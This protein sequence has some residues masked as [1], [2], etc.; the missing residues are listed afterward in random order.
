MAEPDH[1]TAR[2]MAGLIAERVAHINLSQRQ[3]SELVGSST[4]HVCL[5]FNG[6]ATAH[7][8]T[9]DR[10]AELLGV[11]FDVAIGSSPNFIDQ[12]IA[13]LKEAGVHDE[14]E[15]DGPSDLLDEVRTA[16]ANQATLR[17]AVDFLEA[18][19]RGCGCCAPVLCA[20]CACPTSTAVSPTRN[21]RTTNRSGS[22]SAPGAARTE[23]RS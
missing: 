6:R 16:L 12:L 5:V 21:R 4:K 7:P 23:R 13:I 17:A 9:L 19:C 22:V 15:C 10:W 8:N 1:S 2:Q 11:R 14:E 18:A 3:F 20:A